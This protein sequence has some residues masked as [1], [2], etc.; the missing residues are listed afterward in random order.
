MGSILESG[1]QPS[2]PR[3]R[4]IYSVPSLIGT[5]WTG[6]TPENAVSGKV[7]FGTIGEFMLMF[8]GHHEAQ[9]GIEFSVPCMAV[10]FI[11]QKVGDAFPEHQRLQRYDFDPGVEGLT[12]RPISPCFS[13]YLRELKDLHPEMP[14]PGGEK[15]NLAHVSDPK[16]LEEQNLQLMLTGDKSWEYVRLG[17]KWVHRTYTLPTF[18]FGPLVGDDPDEDSVNAWNYAGNPFKEMFPNATNQSWVEKMTARNQKY[19]ERVHPSNIQAVVVAT[20]EE[21]ERRNLRARK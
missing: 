7:F 21:F 13:P 3:P 2:D 1:L 4:P 16:F 18:L 5:N 14:L 20:F 10:Y 9:K 6:T 11:Y 17:N 19:L 8:Q 15:V 12:K